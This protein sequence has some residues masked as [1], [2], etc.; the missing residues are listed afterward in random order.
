MRKSIRRPVQAVLGFIFALGALLFLTFGIIRTWGWFNNNYVKRQVDYQRSRLVAGNYTSYAGDEGTAWENQTCVNTGESLPLT[1][2]WM[3]GGTKEIVSQKLPIDVDKPV[4][5]PEISSEDA[6]RIECQTESGCTSAAI[7]NAMCPCYQECLC[8]KGLDKNTL[9]YTKMIEAICGEDGTCGSP[10]N[11]GC[12][13]TANLTALKDCQD[14]CEDEYN[15]CLSNNTEPCHSDY[16]ICIADPFIPEEQ[17]NADRKLCCIPN[18]DKCLNG[19]LADDGVDG[20][21]S[22][23]GSTG[24]VCALIG[25]AMELEYAANDCD[26]PWEIAWWGGFGA[27][28]KELRKAA[29]KLR[30]NANRQAALAATYSDRVHKLKA[31]C[32]T[33][34]DCISI[35]K[36]HQK[37]DTQ[38][39]QDCFKVCDDE[40][41]VC[42]DKVQQEDCPIIRDELSGVWQTKINELRQDIININAAVAFMNETVSP[43]CPNWARTKCHSKWHSECTDRYTTCRF[44]HNLGREVC[45]FDQDGYNTCYNNNYPPCVIEKKTECCESAYCEDSGSSV[46]CWALYDWNP[47]P[48]W[49]EHYRAF[50]LR[51]HTDKS[52]NRDCSAPSEGCDGSCTFEQVDGN[53][54]PK[55][56]LEKLAE[57]LRLSIPG[58]EREIRDLR[59][60]MAAIAN[61]CDSSQ[62]STFDKQIEC[63][64]IA[65]DTKS[66]W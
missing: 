16:D 64:G 3:Y 61:C 24:T 57:T 28:A 14:D 17:C 45:T 4:Y 50:R 19:V 56:G 48:W 65:E 1:D 54:C 42:M 13:R 40:T 5:P 21:S 62:Y 37:V 22:K 63:I 49:D 11:Y 2:E 23:F 10:S 35:S 39:K 30:G 31:C 58:I 34:G 36:C 12:G 26:D 9:T 66:P 53:N 59:A 60:K 46:S 43:E 25:A 51:Q 29:N 15:N 6:C 47:S 8:E 33:M 52:E 20:C 32:E 27:T 41:G 18:Y 55:C 44:N 38:E 7:F